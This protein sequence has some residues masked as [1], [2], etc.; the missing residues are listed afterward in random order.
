M[1]APKRALLFA[2][3]VACFAGAAAY[4]DYKWFFVAAGVAC[5]L[6]AFIF[7]RRF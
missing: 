7:T 3:S 5:V 1:N 4:A 2:T 6:R